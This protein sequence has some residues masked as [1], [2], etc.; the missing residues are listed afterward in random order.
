MHRIHFSGPFCR[1]LVAATLL[2][3]ATPGLTAEPTPEATAQPTAAPKIF[4]VRHAEK[5]DDQGKSKDPALS[6]AG[7]ARAER[8]AT[9]LKD[10]AI[11]SVY[12]TEAKR[13]QQTAEP[14]ARLANVKPQVV[15]AADTAA[16][17]AKV[18]AGGGNVLVVAHS[19]TIPEIIKGLGVAESLA[20][21]ENEYDNLFIW[22]GGPNPQLL[23]IRYE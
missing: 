9:L 14:L 10:A 15:P 8:L 12:V 11:T 20:L 23:R 2:A 1:L 16:L 5:V 22:T 13:T 19:N 3:F 18:K 21:P 7:R 6:E 4:L 17:L